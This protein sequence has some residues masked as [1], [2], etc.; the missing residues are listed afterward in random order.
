MS[1]LTSIP[2]CEVCVSC[3]GG[4][5]G[6]PDFEWH[7]M[8]VGEACGAGD[9]EPLT[10]ISQVTIRATNVISDGTLSMEH[11]PT[12]MACHNPVLG[13]LE[14]GKAAHEALEAI[15]D[16]HEPPRVDGCRPQRSNRKPH[17]HIPGYI[18]ER[19]HPD[20]GHL[21]I[22][23][24]EVS[25]MET[26]HK[27]V[28]TLERAPLLLDGPPASSTGPSFTSLPKAREWYKAELTAPS[29]EWARE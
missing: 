29:F 2:L 17:N 8:G 12:R 23:N 1:N 21:V 14:R 26:E 16:D 15:L 22:W 13:S 19:R 24:A 10:A 28:I 5:V 27:Y 7:P 9:H 4:A 3:M 25:Y 18:T 11:V 20:G 6:E